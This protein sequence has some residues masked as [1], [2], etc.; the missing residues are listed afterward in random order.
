MFSVLQE[1]EVRTTHVGTSNDFTPV[2]KMRLLNPYD[3]VRLGHLG[4]PCMNTFKLGVSHAFSTMGYE[5]PMFSS[6]AATSS[7]DREKV[8]QQHWLT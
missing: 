7:G 3:S 2:R 5:I 4:G 6:A 1:D 8:R